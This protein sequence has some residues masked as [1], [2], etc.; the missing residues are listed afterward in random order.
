M[1]NPRRTPDRHQGFTL[2]EVMLA[3]L[4]LVLGFIGMIQTITLGSG[5]LDTARKQT[6]A[7]QIAQAEIEKLR[8]SPWSAI[9]GLTTAA[10]TVTIDPYFSSINTGNPFTCT[11]TV[12]N[13]YTSPVTMRQVTF[14]VSW[15]S[16]TGVPHGRSHSAY[17]GQNGL[18]LTYQRN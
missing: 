13:V 4:I 1:P 7:A 17:F 16:V 12:S 9:S 10:R 5:L 18:S 2:L 8:L 3:S 14:T 6:L 11:R 15:L